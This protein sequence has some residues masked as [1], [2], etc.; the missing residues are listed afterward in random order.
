MKK[1]DNF[2]RKI[3]K[4]TFCSFI[5]SLCGRKCPRV[6]RCSCYYFPPMFKLWKGYHPLKR[7]IF[8]PMFAN[9]VQ[10][11]RRWAILFTF[12]KTFENPKMIVW[13][14]RFDKPAKNL[15]PKSE[16]NYKVRFFEEKFLSSKRSFAHEECRFDNLAE[17]FFGS[18]LKKTLGFFEIG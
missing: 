16:K 11:K 12:G 13:T 2:E 15:S 5:N 7:C 10:V 9:C 18:F 4:Y 6:S 8:Y 17:K 14:L 1:Q 3:K